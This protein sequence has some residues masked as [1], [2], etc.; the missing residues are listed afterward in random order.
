LHRYWG[1]DAVA[2]FLL[3]YLLPVSSRGLVLLQIQGA[4]SSVDGCGHYYD[5]APS[6]VFLAYTPI[7]MFEIQHEDPDPSSSL[8]S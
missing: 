8:L 1:F 2:L 7:S 3:A 5:A 4:A 6:L